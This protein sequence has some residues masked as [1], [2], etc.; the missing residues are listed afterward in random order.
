MK[1]SAVSWWL[2][3]ALLGLAAHCCCLFFEAQVWLDAYLISSAEGISERKED[4]TCKAIKFRQ[5]SDNLRHAFC[6]DDALGE[7]LSSSSCRL[8]CALSA[9]KRAPQCRDLLALRIRLL[10]L[11]TQLIPQPVCPQRLTA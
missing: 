4:F 8:Q 7:R 5:L 3:E 10:L 6:I 1:A 11:G 9:G 2:P